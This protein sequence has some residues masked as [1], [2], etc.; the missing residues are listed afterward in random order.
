[1]KSV[2]EEAVEGNTWTIRLR[3]EQHDT[4]IC[5]MRRFIICTL[6]KIL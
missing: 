6:H 4:D 3:K 1:M 5:V 2:C